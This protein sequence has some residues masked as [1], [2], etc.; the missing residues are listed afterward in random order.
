MTRN[1]QTKK[2]FWEAKI[3]FFEKKHTHPATIKMPLNYTKRSLG[4]FSKTETSAQ[5]VG[6][7]C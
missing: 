7:Q 5:M 2:I 3:D 1:L 4:F 6:W